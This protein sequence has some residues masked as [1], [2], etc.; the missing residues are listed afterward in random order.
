MTVGATGKRGCRKPRRIL[1]DPV[2]LGKGP[3]PRWQEARRDRKIP[4]ASVFASKPADAGG[5]LH[6]EGNVCLARRA[7]Y[8]QTRGVKWKELT[9]I[10]A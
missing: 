2:P 10:Q 7:E 8:R 1:R 3:R 9:W 5:A 6:S 4:D